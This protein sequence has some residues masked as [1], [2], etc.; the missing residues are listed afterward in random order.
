MPKYYKIYDSKEMVYVTIDDGGS[1]IIK[2]SAGRKLFLSRYQAKLMKLG[3]DH[4]VK[5][6]FKNTAPSDVH[7]EE[8]K[9][10]KE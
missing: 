6:L 3:I 10:A 9:P 7:V 1:V 5:E 8:M 2:D 4:I